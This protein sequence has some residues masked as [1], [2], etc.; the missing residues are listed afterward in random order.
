MLCGLYFN[1]NIFVII[2]LFVPISA[3]L[4]YSEFF[5]VNVLG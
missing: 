5:L 2:C 4:W 3:F 1:R